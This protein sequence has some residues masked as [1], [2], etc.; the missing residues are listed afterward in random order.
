MPEEHKFVSEEAYQAYISNRKPELGD[1]LI[2]R[3]GA[4][5]GET[6][7]IDKDLEFCIYVSLGLIQPFKEYINS[8]YLAYVFNSSYGVKYAKGNISSKGGSAG[9]FNLGRIRSFLIPLPPL[10]EQQAIVS[11]LDELMRACDEL[12]ASIRTSQQQNEMLLQQV[13]REALEG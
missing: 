4:G 10:S 7:V 8:N 13:L 5:I 3:V 12:E 11:K 9:N 2:G 1:L 6:A